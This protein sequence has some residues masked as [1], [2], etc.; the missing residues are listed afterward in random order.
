[1][2]R[3]MMRVG[4]FAGSTVA[5]F[6]AL[7]SSSSCQKKAVCD[8]VVGSCLALTVEGAGNYD[9][10]RTE[11]LLPGGQ[12]RVGNTSGNIDLPLTLRI[13]PPSG[14]SSADV[15]GVAV[16][17]VLAS[18][19]QASGR[20]PSSFAWPEGA[21]IEATVTLGTSQAD[22]AVVDDLGVVDQASPDLANPD[23]A[24]PPPTLRW[25]PESTGSAI[26]LDLYS[27]WSGGSNQTFAVGGSG[28]ILTRNGTTW[29]QEASP[30]TSN[31][32]G[33]AGFAGTGT[34]TVGPS[35]Y[36]RAATWTADATNLTVGPGESLWSMTPG[37]TAGE[38][39][40]GTENGKIWRRSGAAGGNGTWSVEQ[41]LPLGNRVCAVSYSGGT[42]FAVGQ[43][44]WVG[45]RKST[46]G[47][48]N[49]Q[50]TD[51]AGSTMGNPDAFFGVSAVG[52]D[53]AVAVGSK[54]LAARFSGG[55]WK[56]GTVK[57]DAAGSELNAVWGSPA[58]RFY[59]VGYNG[60][61]VRVD[62]NLTPTALRAD[63]TQSLYG[64]F[65]LSETDLFVVGARN[66][67]D[68]LILHGTP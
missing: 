59:A 68:A 14:T 60:I 4:L 9:S 23:L 61:I 55:S 17:G 35:A 45:V 15:S 39:W 2:N 10:L 11:L 32:Y 16:T 67:G 22:A 6:G 25:T 8:D 13:V 63:N 53:S 49:Y 21:H 28:L 56:P 58:S 7:L 29:S 54:G 62:G 43:R 47:W 38:L 30:T 19:D 64:I 33:V 65:G 66:T 36:R 24:G 44:G 51:L 57:I 27:V 40:V 34:W 50:Y 31:L 37:G 52:A 18:V 42:V 20:T 41:A 3:R 26:R 48:Q 12:V 5:L 1:M 46:G